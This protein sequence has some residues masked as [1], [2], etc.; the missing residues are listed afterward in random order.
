MG[1]NFRGI[2]KKVSKWLKRQGAY[3]SLAMAGVEKNALGQKGDALEQ[4]VNQERRHTQGT[5]AD[6]LKQG[7]VTQEVIMG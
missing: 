7:Q 1:K 3:L 5:L 2:M 4:T 6:S